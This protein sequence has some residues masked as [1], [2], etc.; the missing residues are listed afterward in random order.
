MQQGAQAA[1]HGDSEAVLG[2]TQTE[3]VFG[4]AMLMCLVQQLLLS[5][6]HSRAAGAPQT[7]RRYTSRLSIC[8]N[9]LDANVHR[10][11]FTSSVR[12]RATVIVWA[13]LLIAETCP[14]PAPRM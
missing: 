12:S 9:A 1:L 11:L 4:A 10:E 14:A 6:S 7:M 2:T 3:Q 5:A 8:T 13:K